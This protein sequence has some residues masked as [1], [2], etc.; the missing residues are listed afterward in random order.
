MHVGEVAVAEV[1]LGRTPRSFDQDELEFG[2]QRAQTLLDGRPEQRRTLAPRNLGEAGV[3]EPRDDHL[4]GLLALGLD[5]DRVH[6][7]VGLEACG[8]RL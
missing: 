8:P 2:K 6:A 5:E 3:G 4:A 1:E 7:D